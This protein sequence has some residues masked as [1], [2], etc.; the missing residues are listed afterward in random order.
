MKITTIPLSILCSLILINSIYTF[1]V[2]LESLPLKANQII[3]D[4]PEAPSIPY[5]EAKAK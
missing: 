5:N 4:Q 1:K 3:T 2:S